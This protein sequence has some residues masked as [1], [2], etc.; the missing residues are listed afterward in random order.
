MLDLHPGTRAS[1][2]AGSPRKR[3]SSIDPTERS[4]H[5]GW[6]WPS[7]CSQG[8]PLTIPTPI[9]ERELFGLLGADYV[10]T[11]NIAVGLA[12]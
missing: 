7:G 3:S 4:A 12:V 11:G 8:V 6:T 2:R 1:A 9:P 10:H 5:R